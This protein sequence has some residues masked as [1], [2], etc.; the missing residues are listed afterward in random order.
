MQGYCYFHRILIA[1]VEE[2]PYLRE[3]INERVKNFI[4]DERARHK[5]VCPS[6]GDLLPQLTVSNYTWKHL[7]LPVVK[8]TMIRNVLWIAKKHPS[9]AKISEQYNPETEESRVRLSFAASKTSL[10]LIMFHVRMPF[11]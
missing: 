7:S 6:I 2:F 4:L 11:F 1:A 9:L 5:K 8:E 10:R 3:E